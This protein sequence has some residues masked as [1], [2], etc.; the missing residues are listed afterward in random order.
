[1]INSL[2]TLEDLFLCL[3]PRNLLVPASLEG[4][5][6]HPSTNVDAT[7]QRAACAATCANASNRVSSV[8]HPFE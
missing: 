7:W 1:M 2:E 8:R 6:S 5:S 3:R 4:L